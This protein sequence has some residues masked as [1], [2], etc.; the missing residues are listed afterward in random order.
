MIEIAGITTE[1]LGIASDLRAYANRNC[2]GIPATF[3]EFQGKYLSKFDAAGDPPPR[4][5]WR[6]IRRRYGSLRG[7]YLFLRAT[8]SLESIYVSR[9]VISMTAALAAG[10]A[11]L[12]AARGICDTIQA[13]DVA[14]FT[15]GHRVLAAD[16]SILVRCPAR[17]A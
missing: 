2:G 5:V 13:S 11:G 14:D 3:K 8:C 1:D 12:G 17:S 10:R 6:V 15:E 4:L 9:G 7:L 16:G